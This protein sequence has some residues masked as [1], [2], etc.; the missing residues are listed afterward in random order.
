VRVLEYG[1]AACLLRLIPEFD[2]QE[3]TGEIN[4]EHAANKSKKL[5][6]N[7]QAQRDLT[8][9]RD[10]LRRGVRHKHRN[11]GQLRQATAR[12]DSGTRS[13]AL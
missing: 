10:R 1:S 2:S 3:I 7:K 5:K 13:A 4:R 6:L 8:G 9:S 12:H 11:Q